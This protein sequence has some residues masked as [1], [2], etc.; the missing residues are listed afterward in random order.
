MEEADWTRL[1]RALGKL[2]EAPCWIDDTAMSN[3]SLILDKGRRL[4]R[5]QDL[6]LLVVDGIQELLPFRP[7]ENV[8]EHTSASPS[9]R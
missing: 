8:Y 4:R 2:A 7:V 6:G 5:R 9:E 3:A 1:T